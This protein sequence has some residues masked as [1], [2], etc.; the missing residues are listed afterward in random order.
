ML[1]QPP[2][3]TDPSFDA[4]AATVRSHSV[5]FT[6]LALKLRSLSTSFTALASSIRSP[7]ESFTALAT[8]ILT[9][10]R[11]FTAFAATIRASHYDLDS[12]ILLVPD[13]SGVPILVTLPKLDILIA[14][15]LP[16][17]RMTIGIG[18]IG[19]TILPPPSTQKLT[20]LNNT[21]KMVIRHPDDELVD[22]P[23]D[24]L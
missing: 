1:N 13:Y 4:V 16:T 8:R 22:I 5:R 10:A 9:L 2:R 3:I 24:K 23:E 17:H 7:R 15:G 21:I 11:S 19:L 6:A 14:H 20:V 18:G 12:I